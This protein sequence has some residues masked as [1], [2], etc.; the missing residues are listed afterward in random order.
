MPVDRADVPEQDRWNVEALYSTEDWNKEFQVMCPTGTGERWPQLVKFKGK[1]GSSA[2]VLAECLQESSDIDRKL[3]KLYTYAH[4]RHDE[5][6]AAPL[7]KEGYEKIISYLHAFRLETSWI[8]P[9][10]QEIDDQTMAS[11]LQDPVLADYKIA[12]ERMRRL[13]PHTLLEREERLMALS[14]KALSTASNTF[15]AMNNADLKF[16]TIVDGSGKTHELTH[17]TYNLYMRNRDRVLRENAYK[18][19]HHTFGGFENTF[20]EL[21]SGKVQ[22]HVFN[23]RSRNYESCLQ[24]ALFP[25]EIDT[26]VYEQLITSVRN[27]LPALH[28]YM[29]LR[30]KILGNDELHMYDLHVPLVPNVDIKMDFNEAVEAVIASVAP[31]GEEYQKDLAKGLLE[32]R[33]VDRYENTRKRSGAYSSGCYDSM[34]YVLMNY[35]GTFNDAMT[36]AHECG[37]SMHSLLSRRGQSYEYAQYPI[38]V[39]EVASTFNEELLIEYLMEK[40]TDPM[41]KAFIINQQIEDIRS[42]FFRQTMFAEFELQLHKWAEQEVPLTPQLLKSSYHKL[43]EDYFGKDVVV[44]QETSWEWSRIPHFYYNFYVYQY[45]TG[46]SAA[47]ALIEELHSKGE[48][49]RKHYLQFLSSGCVKGPLE[50]LKIAGVDMR[51]PQAVQATIDRFIRLVKELEEL[52]SQPQSTVKMK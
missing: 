35:H 34:P 17:G 30:K 23:A 28:K 50:L 33:W 39:A 6:I 1:L 45:A 5:D 29:A 36:L 9:E 7:Y 21:I 43:N 31:L 27:G 26:A 20:C 38:F 13:R 11:Y 51:K 32:D 52:L 47:S 46:L 4:L 40:L 25:H 10:I 3:T 15:S 8:E 19:L 2:Q 37:H 18:T 24:A 49:A 16:G 44:D 12:L 41:Q 42:T 22:T 14:G 48:E